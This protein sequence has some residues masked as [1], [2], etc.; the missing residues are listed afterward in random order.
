MVKSFIFLNIG[1][2]RISGDRKWA[3][4]AQKMRNGLPCVKLV[5]RMD[6]GDNFYRYYKIDFLRNLRFLARRALRLFIS[7]E[8]ANPS[9]LDTG[10]FSI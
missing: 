1:L 9:F 8:H 5:W 6:V 2:P 7:I 4:H 3:P 10:S